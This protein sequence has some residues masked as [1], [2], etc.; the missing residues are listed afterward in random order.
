M[1][2][3]L[4]VHLLAFGIFQHFNLSSK[5]YKINSNYSFSFTPRYYMQTFI[6]FPDLFGQQVLTMIKPVMHIKTE[7][8]DKPCDYFIKFNFIG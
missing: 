5:I 3:I 7:G 1:K 4:N 6:H 8:C 2:S